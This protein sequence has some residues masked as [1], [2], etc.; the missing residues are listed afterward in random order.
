[1]AANSPVTD[2][3]P[4]H[5][6]TG[7]AVAERFRVESH[8]GLTEDEAAARLEQYGS[9]ELDKEPPVPLWR[10]A[11]AQFTDPLVILLLVAVAISLLVWLAEGADELPF[12]AIVIAAILLL[13]AVIGLV[14]E[15]RAQD[16]VDALQEM[17]LLEATVR[18]A[19]VGDGPGEE[20]RILAREVVPGDIVVL[21]EG[22]AVPADLRL[23]AVSGLQVAEAAL[24]GESEAVT[25]RVEAVDVD[26]PLGDRLCMAYLGTE[27]T[28]GAATGVVVS[29]GMSTELGHIADLLQAQPEEPTPLQ[30]EV[31]RVGRFLGIAVVVIAVVV[32]GAILATTDIEDSSDLVEVALVGVSLAVAAVPEGL[33]A[34]LTVVL[35][36]GVQRLAASGAIV[37]KLAS[38]ETLGSASVICSDKTG[39]LTR[40][41]MTIRRIVTAHLDAELT[42]TGY[43]PIGETLTNGERVTDRVGLDEARAVLAGG[44][45]ASDATLHHDPDAGWTVIGDPTEGAFLAARPKVGLHPDD[46]AARFSALGAVPFDAER[47]MMTTVHHDAERAAAT[48]F[49]KGAPDVLL[50]RCRDERVGESTQVLSEERRAEILAVVDSLADQAFRALAVAYRRLEHPSLADAGETLDESLEHG[51]TWAGVVGIIDP[52]RAEATDAIA[53]ARRAGIRTVMITGDHPRTA[54]RIAEELELSDRP[55]A[56]RDGRLRVLTGAELDALDQDDQPAVAEAV[57]RSDVYARVTPEH[58]LRLVQAMR[59]DG[60]IVSMTGDGV[61]DAPALRAAEIGVAMGITGTDVSKGAADMIL[62][63][64]NYATIV[65]AVNEGRGVFSNIRKVLRYLLSSNV[66]EVFTMFFGVVAA[67]LIGLDGASDE[68]TLVVPLLATQILWINLL[69]DAFPALALGVDP[70][71]PDLMERPPR[72]ITDRLVDSR[73]ISGIALIGAVMAAVT[74]VALD[75]HLPGGLF[76]GDRSVDYART[77]AFTTLVLAQVFNA[78]NSKSDET[79]ALPQLF[80]NRLLWLACAVAVGL[81]LVVVHIGVLNDAFGTEPLTLQSWLI[82]TVLAST[83][84]WVD[85]VRKLVIRRR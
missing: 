74:L 71:A 70:P 10:R 18:R 9:N 55:E 72:Q 85:E 16:A 12:D 11:L 6:A 52:P 38:V 62:A 22:D 51:L 14:Q 2:E 57:R 66:G 60:H 80:T 64:D 49:T 68:S 15:S 58:K 30:E 61:N 3:I 5:V 29:T 13:N 34:I 23:V 59:A 24:T 20:E 8:R 65:V 77:T 73:M 47:K 31:A 36:L 25:K 7:S 45:L 44:S 1:M 81:Q 46:V 41:E 48:V 67:G 69:T 37:K 43:A 53:V 63:D 40:N 26:A 56:M 54:V 78:F 79:S 84:L 50:A 17:T 4:A 21:G 39:T 75:W 27:V 82:C 28:R 42:G 19:P 76:E 83:V 35:A 32:M 33:P